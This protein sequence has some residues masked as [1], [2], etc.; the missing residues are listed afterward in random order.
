VKEL[1]GGVAAEHEKYEEALR[2][3]DEAVEQV[4]KLHEGKINGM[5]AGI[6]ELKGRWCVVV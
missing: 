4:R 2:K 5:Q 6:K 3:R 1:Q